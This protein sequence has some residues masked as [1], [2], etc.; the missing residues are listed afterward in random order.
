MNKLFDNNKQI[1]EYIR[2]QVRASTEKL[3]EHVKEKAKRQIEEDIYSYNPVEYE[4]TNTLKDSLVYRAGEDRKDGIDIFI[5][6]DEDFMKFRSL[7]TG[8]EVS[9]FLPFWIHEGYV[10]NIFN[11]IANYPWMKPRPYM[12]HTVEKLNKDKSH[13][14]VF[15]AELKKRG[16]DV[17]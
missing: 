17:F 11:N 9:E 10:P 4:R 1:M 5:E 13:I 6:H 16:L 14:K 3:G 8:E 2:K 12:T 7:V 15:K